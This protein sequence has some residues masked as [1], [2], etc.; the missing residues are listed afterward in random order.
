MKLFT[1]QK[2]YFIYILQSF[3]WIVT[4]ALIMLQIFYTRPLQDD[5][6]LL[7]YLSNNSWLDFVKDVWISQ[8]G[9]LWPYGAQGLLLKG[10]IYYANFTII[11]IWTLITLSTVSYCNYQIF[12]WF[13]N[14]E[15]NLFG[16]FKIATI[17]S[18]SYLGF[19]GLF[20]PGLIAAYS[21]HMAAF[22]HLWPITL[23]LIAV[24][25]ANK[26]SDNIAVALIL[27]L[28]IGNSNIAESFA[29][30]V[31]LLGI[32]L[33]RKN[34][35]NIAS[36]IIKNGKRFYY[37]LLTG[38]I[39]GFITILASPGFWNRAQNSVGLPDSGEEFAQRFLKSFGSFSADLISHPMLYISFFIGIFMAI[40]RKTGEEKEKVLNK[41]QLL[42]LLGLILFSSLTIG[43]T[44]A[45]VSW[46]QSTGLYQIF[47]PLAF[48]IG[49]Y[50]K[51][52]LKLNINPRKKLFIS[53]LIVISL[54]LIS[55]RTGLALKTRAS[56]WDAAFEINY[57]LIKNDPRAKLVGAETLYPGFNLGVEDVNRWEW[58]RNGYANWVSNPKFKTEINC[59]TN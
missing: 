25:L 14:K 41:L 52:F 47:I 22:S 3:F 29:A 21:Y 4:F 37:T 44:F 55:L 32:F 20:T 24:H 31:C 58:M 43:S 16:K 13:F 30:M 42:L 34:S 28:L 50:H 27:G 5:Y 33:V 54:I 17:I 7:G 15:F 6:F 23:L 10:S 36:Q 12:R 26:G 40:P 48:L 8:G 57:C 46:H 38:V 2:K 35:N 9:N 39:I 51:T 45:Y 11:A 53:F 56:E 1:L 19:E 18:I 59:V 49:V